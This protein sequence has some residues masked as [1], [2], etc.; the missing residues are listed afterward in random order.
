[1]ELEAGRLCPD[2][3]VFRN[4][5]CWVLRAEFETKENEL[6]SRA[7]S[8]RLGG[9]KVLGTSSLPLGLVQL[10]PSTYTL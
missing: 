6:Q 8:S 7:L 3:L 1:M 5:L 2:S 10:S 9:F 4:N